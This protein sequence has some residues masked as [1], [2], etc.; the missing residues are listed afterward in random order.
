M[1]APTLLHFAT[2]E[3]KQTWMRPLWTGEEVWCQLFSEP[4]AGSD[5]AAV[6]ASARRDGDAWIVNGQK[7]WT[8]LAHDARWALLL[9]RTDPSLPKH[10][11]LSY[12]SAT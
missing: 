12:S 11:G 9:V 2:E 8:S 3:Q 4:G 1:A 5:L 6:G 10:K 7:V